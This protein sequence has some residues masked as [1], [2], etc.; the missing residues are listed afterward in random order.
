IHARLFS[1]AHLDGVS[2]FMKFVAERYDEN[3]EIRCPCRK[4]L[5][6]VHQH[7]GLVEDH[8][9]IHGMAST[10]NKWIHYGE[11]LESTIIQNPEH[12]DEQIGFND[13]V[14]VDEYEEDG[15]NDRIPD[16]V[17][18]LFDLEDE[19]K[20]R[21]SMFSILLEEMKQELY[22]DTLMQHIQDFFFNAAFNA[23]LTLLASAFPDCSIP[24]SYQEAK[25]LIRA[26][27]LGY[28]LIHVCPNNCVLFRKKYEKHD[29]CLVCGASRWKDTN[30]SK[31]IPEKVLRHFPL[32]PRLKRFFA[33]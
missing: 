3:T 17:R 23:L 5:N 15:P 12:P 2:E 11:Q 6:R 8:L 7:E 30:G 13:D 29:Q 14:A 27:G 22:P 19:S 1:E 32:I 20:G 18:E 28:V 9:Y 10:Y 31:R 26:L 4:C 33:S 25:K 21:K 16:M 24:A